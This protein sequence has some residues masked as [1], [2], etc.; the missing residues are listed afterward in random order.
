[1]KKNKKKL[2][3]FLVGIA[4][5]V[6]IPIVA[7]RYK[8]VQ[9][10]Y[11]GIKYS[12]VGGTKEKPITQGGHFVGFGTKVIQYPVRNTSIKSSGISAVSKDGKRLNVTVR[13]L[14][15]IQESKAVDIFREFG[16]S[17]IKSIEDGWLY[18]QLSSAIK[19]VYA[20]YDVL[21]SIAEKAG[22]IQNE[23]QE[24]FHQKAIEKGFDVSDVVL[25]A[26]DLDEET[27]NTIDSIIKAGQENEKA[28]KD[29]ETAKTK[30]DAD[31]YVKVKEAQAEADANA[32][33]TQSISDQLIRYTEAQARMKH[34]WVTVQGNDGGVIVDEK[35]K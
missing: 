7:F 31:Y 6:A 24:Q 15:K 23:V 25:S 5:V 16:T 18:S 9:N 29:A 28:K 34:G 27:Q 20:K 8:V 21:Q 13:Y 33:L 10:G 30:A 26:P 22:D 14:Y 2:I 11:V 17:D 32:K 1:M 3:G 12:I 19:N 4:L 35:G